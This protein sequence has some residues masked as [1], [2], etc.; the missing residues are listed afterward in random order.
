[1]RFRRLFALLTSA[2]MLH[3]T[4]V[5]G[6]DA[7]A[8]HGVGASAQATASDATAPRH[9]MPMAGEGMSAA[10]SAGRST[11]SEGPAANSATPPCEVPTQQHCCAAL[12]GCS[13]DSAVTHAHESFGATASSS[14]GIAAG[15][16]DAPTSFAS[17]PEPPPPKA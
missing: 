10:P 2:A 14:A 6:D 16:D 3:L 7:C 11:L 5:A 12:V 9:E 17:A 13:V 4:M 8:T 1:M 15:R